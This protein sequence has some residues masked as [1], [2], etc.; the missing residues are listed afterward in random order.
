MKFPQLMIS[1][2]D[3]LI[4]YMTGEDTVLDNLTGTVIVDDSGMYPRYY[5]CDDWAK[6]C[7]KP[8]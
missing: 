8:F 7:F 2:D 6:E 5:Q 1:T 3:Q 4:V